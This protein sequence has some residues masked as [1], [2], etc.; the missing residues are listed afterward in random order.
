MSMLQSRNPAMGVFGQDQIARSEANT[1]TI[2]GTV[3]ATAIL[4][5]IVSATG[6]FT[7][8]QMVSGGPL[9]KFIWPVMI[10]SFIGGI[11]VSFMIYAKPKMARVIAPIHAVFQGVF[12]GALSYIIPM[13]FLGNAADPTA[14]N[15][16]QTLIVQAILATFGIAGGMLLGYAT[17]IIRV[18]PVFQKVMVTAVIGLLVYIGALLLLPLIGINI[19]NGY[20]DTG[21]MGIGF[22]GICVALASLFLVLDFQYIEQGVKTGQPKYME[23]VGAWGLMVTLVWLY[24]EILRLLSKLQSRD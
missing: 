23:W 7:W 15:A 24:I 4:L 3:S 9:T 8:Q 21:M 5:A 2:G 13:Q 12:V 10:G 18:G 11:V 14:G 1:M 6:I 17:G 20:A 19:W 16:M 22:T